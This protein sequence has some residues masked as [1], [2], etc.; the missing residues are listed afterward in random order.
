MI[1][2]ISPPEVLYEYSNVFDMFKRCNLNSN[3]I[4]NPKDFS[5]SIIKSKINQD[6]K[7]HATTSGGTKKMEQSVLSMPSH[8]S[9]SK[10]YNSVTETVVLYN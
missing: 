6:L 9:H 3:S 7:Q 1:D 8:N 4:S 2:G 10:L 5:I